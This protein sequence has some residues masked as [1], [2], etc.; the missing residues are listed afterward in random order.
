MRN[1][2]GRR[3]EKRQPF[4]LP[5][6]S[7]SQPPTRLWS[8]ILT[9]PLKFI[10]KRSTKRR[11]RG[12]EK[13]RMALEKL[14]VVGPKIAFRNRTV[15]LHQSLAVGSKGVSAP[16]PFWPWQQQE[17]RKWD[18][19]LG[20]NNNKKVI[21]KPNKDRQSH[22]KDSK[23]PGP[24]PTSGFTVAVNICKAWENPLCQGWAV[25][26]LCCS[27]AKSGPT[28]CDPKDYRVPGFPGPSPSPGVCSNS[29]P[30]S[31]WCHP[32]VSSSITPFSSIFPWKF[33]S[34]REL[35]PL[36][37]SAVVEVH[38]Y[39]RRVFDFHPAC[40]SYPQD[41][42]DPHSFSQQ[43][44]WGWILEVAPL[45]SRCANSSP[46]LLKWT[47]IPGESWALKKMHTG[48]LAWGCCC[49]RGKGGRPGRTVRNSTFLAQ[50]KTSPRVFVL[51]KTKNKFTIN[52]NRKGT[53]SSMTI[54]SSPFINEDLNY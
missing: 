17:V 35:P 8:Q 45:L 5:P 34:F 54:I 19:P 50:N 32:T 37:V 53:G 7:P 48:D 40:F 13:K 30:L 42:P 14:S 43:C 52:H 28:L 39:T 22:I 26:K 33:T 20:V 15:S 47:Q 16:F 9:S 2:G 11:E 49:P 12:T 1:Q 44:D 31:W 24:S 23:S 38:R 21:E 29:C 18:S 27:V 4:F 25:W 51:L 46:K 3:E 41:K 36:L 6:H 10:C